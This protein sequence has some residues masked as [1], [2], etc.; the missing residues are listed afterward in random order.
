MSDARA[1]PEEGR[2]A[3]GQK[4]VNKALATASN[5]LFGEVVL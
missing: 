3:A 1:N 4:M 2:Q 5:E